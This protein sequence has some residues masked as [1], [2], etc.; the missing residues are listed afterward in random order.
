VDETMTSPFGND[1]APSHE[2]LAAY[3]DGEF[4]HRPHLRDRKRQI[5]A[6]LAQHPEAGELEAQ[7]ELSRLWKVTT[8]SEP[9]PAT[10]AKVWARVE[11]S[12]QRL[13]SKRWPTALWLAG[14]AAMGAA[15]AVLIVLLQG[16]PA[17]PD[18]PPPENQLPLPM[19]KHHDA[20][21]RRLAV[22]EMDNQR[23]AARGE[24]PRRP[25]GDGQFV[26]TPSQPGHR[27]EETVEVLEIAT[28]DE[29]DI[30]HIAGADIGSLVV[31]RLP[32]A[33]P[34]VL[35]TQEEVDVRPP[36]NGSA[37]TEIRVV[38]SSPMVWTPLPN[39]NEE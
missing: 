17:E 29:V 21:P 37:R 10:W 36:V 18:T 7:M 22:D 27:P 1:W 19:A 33:G 14:I 34:M 25:G 26:S 12:P 20:P 9:S 31:G 16:T 3:A 32:L 28:S 24:A 23:V 8:P 5:E 11:Q 6:W 13:K 30:L 38:G 15:A 35:L 2:L 4:D 39:E